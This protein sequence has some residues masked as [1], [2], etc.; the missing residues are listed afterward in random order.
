MKRILAVLLV[1]SMVLSLTACHS[2]ETKSDAAEIITGAQNSAAGEGKAEN[3]SASQTVTDFSPQGEYN[4]GVVLVKVE[5]AFNA[6]DLGELDY[7][8]AE[9]LYNGSK[10]YAVQLAEGITTEEAVEYL[11]SL[12]TL[13]GVDYDYVMAVTEKECII[14]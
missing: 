6:N 13:A 3:L 9:V 1:C 8:A 2:V 5:D 4:E 10:W 14:F 7:T 12:D 11:L